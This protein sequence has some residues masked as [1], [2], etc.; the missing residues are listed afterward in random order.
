MIN[1]QYFVELLV[2]LLFL[3]LAA[4]A[5]KI[6]IRLFTHLARFIIYMMNILIYMFLVVI[7]FKLISGDVPT[8]FNFEKWGEIAQSSIE[9]LKNISVFL[10]KEVI[11][12]IGRNFF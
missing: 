2:I 1:T 10:F 12:I 6:L 4:F 5:V 8:E 9:A 3:R 11:K 7:I